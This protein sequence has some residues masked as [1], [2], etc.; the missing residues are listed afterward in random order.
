MRYYRRR[1]PSIKKAEVV[2]IG[3]AHSPRLPKLFT[4]TSPWWLCSFSG[5][6]KLVGLRIAS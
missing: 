3:F 5:Q 6:P 2:A 4:L 1:S